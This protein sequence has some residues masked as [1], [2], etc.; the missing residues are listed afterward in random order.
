MTED[1]HR[2]GGGGYINGLIAGVL[3]G[4]TAIFLSSTSKGRRL[5]KQIRKH[6]KKTFKELEELV[7][8]IET[9]DKKLTYIQQLQEKGRS[10]AGQFF[11]RDGK[12]LG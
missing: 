2:G 3:L 6:G 11:K 10:V 4:A 7:G 9:K 12:T 1:R 8:D 5:S